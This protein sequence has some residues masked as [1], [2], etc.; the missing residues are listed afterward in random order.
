MLIAFNLKSQNSTNNKPYSFNNSSYDIEKIEAINLMAPNIELL[1]QK[2]LETEKQ[3]GYEKSGES[4][5][6]SYSLENSGT[7]FELENGDRLWQLKIESKK[8]KAIGLVYEDFY[9]SKASNM[10]IYNAAKTQVVGPL[11]YN[12]NPKTKYFS[13]ELIQGDVINLEF[14][15]PNAFKGMSK[16]NIIE[17]VY[18]Y[19]NAGIVEKFNPNKDTGWGLS[20]DCE[21]N[22]NCSPAGDNWQDEKR[23]VASIWLRDGSSWGWCSGTLINNTSQDETPY[24]LTADHCG[25]STASTDDFSVWEFYFNYESPNCTTPSSEP[26]YDVV[27]GSTKKAVGPINGGSDFLLL[28][29]NSTPS[30]SVNPYYNGW[31]RTNTAYSSGVG[32]HH[33]HGD[34]KAISAYST[35]LIAAS[36]VIG[37]SQTATNSEW[38][39]TWAETGNGTGVTEGGSSGSPLFKDNG[40]QIGTL[41][42]GS[43]YCD[44]I[45]DPDYYGKFWYHWDQNGTLNSERLKPWLDPANTGA[46]T[47]NGFDP[48]LSAPVPKFIAS[49]TTIYV[50]SSVDFTDQSTGN[51]T[52][53]TWT[54]E[55]GSSTTSSLQNPSITYNT[56]GTYD[57]SLTVTNANGDSLLTKSNYITVIEEAEITCD[58]ITNFSGTASLYGV[59]G[60]VGYLSGNNGYGDLSKAEYFSNYA[61]YTQIDKFFV[62]FAIA[63]GNSSTITFNVR[64]QTSGVPGNIIGTKTLSIS[65]IVTSTNNSEPVVVDFD[66]NINIPGPFYFEVVL[67]TQSGDTLAIITNADGD[68]TTNTAWEKWSDGT[69]SSYADAWDISLNHAIYADVCTGSAGNEDIIVDN[70]DVSV[71]PNPSNQKLFIEVSNNIK[72]VEKIAIYN[73]IGEQVENIKINNSNNKKYELNME[74]YSSG[75]YYLNLTSNN[76]IYVS[77][78]VV[79]K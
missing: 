48:Y 52:S 60:Q 77:K 53:W 50:G 20:E 69:W 24:F 22:V 78:I 25:G 12:D 70:S 8:A 14:I 21:V 64:K 13:T 51:P 58:T 66:P 35:T 18:V 43:S 41:S 19:K 29:L 68:A 30:Q 42:G 5:K 33:P 6:V 17:V 76:K 32:I 10:Y 65:S 7:W 9:I 4:I 62:Y 46:T 2:S 26:T 1:L 59:D 36:P 54:F 34:I 73:I 74:N 45:T 67:P 55:G 47:L 31:D 3:G 37:G 23:G 16:I 63:T 71:Y 11:T 15:E 72:K 57:V 44:A 61:P 27:T 28:E 75:L 38:Q 39:V 79:E 49:S 40:L 56:V